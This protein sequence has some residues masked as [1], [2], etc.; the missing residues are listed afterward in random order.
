MLFLERCLSILLKGVYFLWLPTCIQIRL[1]FW[2]VILIQFFNCL[3]LLLD[4]LFFSYLYQTSA[5]LYYSIEWMPGVYCNL[6]SISNENSEPGNPDTKA[7]I[8]T[9]GL[10]YKTTAKF[11]V[12]VFL[13]VCFFFSPGVEKEEHGMEARMFHLSRSLPTWAVLWTL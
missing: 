7:H 4:T 9:H 2:F 12:L 8:L 5:P 3:L 1:K 11:W 10:I 6:T 13:F